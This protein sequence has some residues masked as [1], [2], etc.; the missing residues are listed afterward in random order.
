MSEAANLERLIVVGIDGSS[1]SEDAPRWAA[2]Q[3]EQ[4]GASVRP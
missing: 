2:R 1:T 3:A 4:T